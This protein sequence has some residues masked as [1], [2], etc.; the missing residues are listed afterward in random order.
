MAKKKTLVGVFTASEDI[1]DFKRKIDDFNLKKGT[2][3]GVEYSFHHFYRN[4][5][6]P[7]DF[8]WK[9][10]INYL[11]KEKK[12]KIVFLDS[13]QLRTKLDVKYLRGEE[14]TLS[15]AKIMF[16]GREKVFKQRIPECEVS[17]LGAKHAIRLKKKAKA[18]F[19]LVLDPVSLGLHNLRLIALTP[20]QQVSPKLIRKR[21][22]LLASLDKTKTLAELVKIKN[23]RKKEKLPK[24]VSPR[25]RKF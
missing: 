23:Q 7:Q 13:E 11:Q 14:L 15:D 12:C 10:V 1:S 16:D 17:V 5:L 21:N 25:T 19:N 6:T 18:D 22:K 4:S 2:K 9:K 3:V 24:K 8:F 20:F